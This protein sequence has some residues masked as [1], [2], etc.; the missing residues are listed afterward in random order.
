MK[1][2]YSILLVLIILM[3]FISPLVVFAEGEGNIDHGGGGMGNSS[4]DN[5]WTGDDGVRVTVVRASDKKPVTIPI[6]FS[7][8]KPCVSV[9]FGEVCKLTYTAGRSLTPSTSDYVCKKPDKAMPK[10]VRTKSRKANIIEIKKYF[11]SEYMIATISK[12]TGFNYEILTNGDYKILLEPIAYMTFKGVNM[13]MTATEA[14][15]YDQQLG[16]ELRRRMVSL[17]NKNLPLAMFLERSDLGYPAWVGSTTTPAADQDIISSLGIGIVRFSEKEEPPPEVADGSYTYRVNTEVITAVTV[18][19]GRSDPD[20]PVTVQFNIGGVIYTVGNVYYPE[21]ESQLAWVRWRTPSVPQTMKINLAVSG[22]GRSDGGVITAKIVD[23]SGNDPPNPLADDTNDSF[24]PTSIPARAEKTRAD[25]S[26]WR[27]WWQA[28]WV[29]EGYWNSYSWTD[30]KGNTHT[31]STWIANWVDRG[32]W[33]FNIDRYYAAFSAD[34]NISCDSKNPTSSGRTMKS[35]Y[36]I[37]ETVTAS[38][39][40]NQSTAVTYPQNAVSYFPEFQY[41]TYWRLLESMQG[42]STTKFEFQ[43]NR[44]STYK[45]RTH[46]TPIWMPDGSYTVNTWVLDSWTPVGMLSMN[47]MDALTI[48]GSLWDD[49]H[50]AP[51]NP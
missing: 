1:K 13:A 30:S 3:S 31:S 51:L 28:H 10:I 9:H 36:G 21:G 14:A 35:G 24:S 2:I 26:V 44:Y 47:L 49:W 25:W 4:K 39:S 6:D 7:N 40:S 8:T 32:W 12:L 22:N 42:G 37:N 16:G 18:R 23:L 20:N 27:P 38:V 50:I 43:K 17:S 34:M 41:K 29:D 19:G 45:N 48:K 15:L 5:Y 46:F 33:E 11:C